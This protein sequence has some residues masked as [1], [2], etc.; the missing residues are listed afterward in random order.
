VN[1]ELKG[2]VAVVTGAGRGLGRQTAVHLAAH[3]A[4]VV[5]VSR[6]AEQLR[7]TEQAIKRAGGLARA[8]SAD[9]SRQ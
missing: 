2:K 7:Q 1:L 4:E 5:V 3:G 6:N 8:I 9:V